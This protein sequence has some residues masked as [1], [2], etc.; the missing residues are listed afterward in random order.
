MTNTKTNQAT[1][2]IE[3]LRAATRKHTTEQLKEIARVSTNQITTLDELAT[4]FPKNESN[5]EK[6]RDLRTVLAAIID[7]IIERLGE[8]AGDK[9]MDELGL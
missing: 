9:F 4:K 6:A 8:D 2:Q 5:T 3:T 1:N 7:V